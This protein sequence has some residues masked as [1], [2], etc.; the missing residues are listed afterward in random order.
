MIQTT[1][2]AN[3][4]R[5]SKMHINARVA[6]EAAEQ[7]RGLTTPHA[8]SQYQ[9]VE[10][11][12]TVPWWVVAVI[13]EREAAQSWAASLAQGDPWS[14]VSIHVPR[15]IGPFTSWIAAAQYAM[16][17]CGP[18]PAYWKDWSAGGALT[19]LEEYNGLGYAN[20]GVASP[21]I[22]AGSDQYVSGKFIADGHYDPHAVDKQIG[23]APLLRMMETV[24]TTIK[25]GV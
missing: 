3:A 13:H 19:L 22:W 17:H 9:V 1:V 14:R 23:C 21:Y 15:G 10:T 2:R 12:T 18:K 16:V 24:D 8:K 5:W 20:R 11:L 6:A 25:I 7:A 4:A